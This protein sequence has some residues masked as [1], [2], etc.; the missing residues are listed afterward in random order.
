MTTP[1][2]AAALLSAHPLYDMERIEID[3][4]PLIGTYKPHPTEVALGL[5]LIVSGILFL[6]SGRLPLMATPEGI[7]R[8]A[9][10]FVMGPLIA[11][12]GMGIG[13]RWIEVKK[14][15]II[16]HS[17]FLPLRSKISNRDSEITWNPKKFGFIY[18]KKE[19]KDST[20]CANI[21]LAAALR[22]Q[23][24]IQSELDNA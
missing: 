2:S 8:E 9:A 17:L 5:V 20:L 23:H 3:L 18:S 6:I 15:E 13:F 7:I 16:S 22:N 14:N 24:H 10:R 21:G 12:L 19:G 4:E 1:S 11:Y